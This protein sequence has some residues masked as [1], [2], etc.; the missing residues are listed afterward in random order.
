MRPIAA[1]TSSP[2]H[3][4]LSFNL[5]VDKGESLL[6]HLDLYLLGR[7]RMRTKRLYSCCAASLVSLALATSQNVAADALARRGGSL[8]TGDGVCTLAPEL[9]LARP[10][11][12]V[13]ERVATLGTSTSTVAAQDTISS[14]AGVKRYGRRASD[15]L[16]LSAKTS[17]AHASHKEKRW[18]GAYRGRSSTA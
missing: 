6:F 17:A 7:I 10:F 16:E 3:V 9:P 18:Q 11:P 12:D 1:L 2:P 5:R 8:N 13:R 4:R 14:A 15:R